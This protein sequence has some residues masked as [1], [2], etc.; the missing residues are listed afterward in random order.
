[1]QS[2]LCAAAAAGVL[3]A[4]LLGSVS[5]AQASPVSRANAV[6]SAKEYLQSQAFSFKS[7]VSQLKYEG[8][9]SSDATYGVT[10]SG[11]NLDEGSCCVCQG[12]PAV[13]GVF[14]QRPDPA[15]GIRRVYAF[16][17]AARSASR[18]SLTTATC[19]KRH[20]CALRGV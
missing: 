14:T 6:R 18:R 2:K 3:T 15:T 17:G 20:T 10:H 19:G 5:A 7:L 8:F 13:A 12:I 1:M 4:L 9:S 16:A 11:A